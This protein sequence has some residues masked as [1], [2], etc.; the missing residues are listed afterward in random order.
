MYI[1]SQVHVT[2]R[3][4]THSN[5]QTLTWVLEHHHLSTHASR[6]IYTQC[7]RVCENM[8]DCRKNVL[9][10]LILRPSDGSGISNSIT[11]ITRN[12]YVWLIIFFL[13]SDLTRCQVRYLMK[14]IKSHFTST[15]PKRNSFGRDEIYKKECESCIQGNLNLKFSVWYKLKS[16][17]PPMHTISVPKI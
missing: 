4:Y 15:E 16:K 8:R 11:M 14:E 3:K 9:Y 12:Q 17:P 5:K 7:E 13:S 10:E 6:P 1:R 2:K